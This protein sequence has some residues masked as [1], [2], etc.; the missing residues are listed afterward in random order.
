MNIEEEFSEWLSLNFISMA[1]VDGKKKIIF[2]SLISDVFN[3][4]SAEKILEFPGIPKRFQN[5]MIHN[6][7]LFI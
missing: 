7:E 6:M 4:I 5:Y 3:P 2:V 1:R